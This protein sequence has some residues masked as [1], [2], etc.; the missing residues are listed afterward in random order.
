MD[1]T[2]LAALILIGGIA[3][4]IIVGVPIAVSIGLSSLGA[5]VVLLGWENGL[6][7]TA[8]RMFTG[9]DSF[10]LLAIPLFVLAGVLMNNGGI[11]G[12]LIDAANVVAGRLPASLGSTTV[13]A[14]GMFGAVSGA[15]V[16]S[17]AAV[18]SVTHPRMVRE[19]YQPPFAAAINV[20]SAPAGM[21]I[22]PSNTFIV[23]SLVSGTSIAALFMA[24]VGPGLLW[25]LACL[26]VVVLLS[27]RFA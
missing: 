13:V 9:I 25:V 22:P 1:P 3:V 4:G 20:A 7:T 16:A 23:Y 19:S 17:A 2:S 18:G 15:A 21:L 10:P 26:T 8:Q 14:N 11:A 5:A 6:S 27:R 12:R 24:G